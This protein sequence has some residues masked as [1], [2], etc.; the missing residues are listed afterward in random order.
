MSGNASN[1]SFVRTEMLAE[2]APPVLETGIIKWLRENLFSSDIYT[3]C[4]SVVKLYQY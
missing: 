1:Q 3:T 4:Y 2:Q